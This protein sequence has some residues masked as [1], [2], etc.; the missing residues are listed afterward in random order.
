M[1]WR[2]EPA[3]IE[4]KKSN[5]Q[6]EIPSPGIRGKRRDYQQNAYPG[7]LSAGTEYYGQRGLGVSWAYTIHGESGAFI[8]SPSDSEETRIRNNHGDI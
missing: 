1:T 4:E 6:M 3:K 7:R 5:G 2:E 8:Q